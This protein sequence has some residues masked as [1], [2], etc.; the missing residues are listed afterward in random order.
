MA[1]SRDSSICERYTN[2]NISVPRLAAD[3]GLSEIRVRQILRDCGVAKK[4]KVIDPD[5]EVDK[6]YSSRHVALGKF[7]IHKRTFD[8][9]VDRGY[10]AKSV[11][12]WSA[13]K[14]AS[15]EKGTYN[16]TLVD[17]VDLAA[18]LSIT[19]EALLAVTTPVVEATSTDPQSQ[20]PSQDQE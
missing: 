19:L 20:S 15:V 7:L 2:E 3:V 17:M 6:T 1:S 14:L 9:G 18:A 16:I 11:L 12:S 10:F 5:E 4:D 8:L 13:S